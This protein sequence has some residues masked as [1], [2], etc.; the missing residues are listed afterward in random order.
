MP[1][2][3]YAHQKKA[4][5]LLIAHN[6]YAL[7][8]EQGTGKTL[9][10]LLHL[11]YLVSIE[12]I[13]N[14]I[15]VAP[16]STIGA[17]SR[18]LEKLPPVKQAQLK[19]SLTV[20][21]YDKVWRRKELTERKWDCMV[22]DEAHAIKHRGSKRSRAVR[23]M[24]SHA[25]YKYILTGTPMSNG[26]LEE[27]WAQF[28]FLNPEIFGRYKDFE[29]RYCEVNQFYKPIRYKRVEELKHIIATHSYRVT[30]DECLDLPEKMDDEVIKIDLRENAKY[31][32]MMD[33]FIAE[34]AIAAENPL[35][36]TIKLRQLCSGF[37]KDDDKLI[38][39]KSDKISVV[40]ELLEARGE[41]KT[42]IFADFKYSIQRIQ[43][44]LGRMKIKHITLDGA[45]KDKTI[46]QKFQKDPSIQVIVCQYQTANAGIDLYASDTIIFY[47]PTLSSM[48]NE[49]AKD[50]IHR[51]GQH[52]PC[53]YYYLIT[54]GTIEVKIYNTLMK[55]R[56]FGKEVLLDFVRQQKGGQ[57]DK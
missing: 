49:Q 33:N 55:G 36:R 9:P 18:D 56:D 51:I 43:R 42:V 26:H 21:N 20:I 37:I 47:E 15:I 1:L 8:M 54:K 50:R 30:K 48:I 19:D 13:R 7:Y 45:Q 17:W 24:S 34:L 41:K 16:L 27:Y 5:E 6:A 44:L 29:D 38:E 53:S 14:A 22:L 31:K 25:K 23:R 39:L 35:T 12:E 52:H 10:I 40:Q 11:A 32:Q 2:K 46:W 3:L 28:D 57:N 4:R